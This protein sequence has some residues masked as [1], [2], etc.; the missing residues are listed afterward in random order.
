[1]HMR[2]VLLFFR[3]KTGFA[4]QSG[5]NTSMMKPGDLLTNGLSFLFCKAPQWLLDWLGI[6]PD[7]E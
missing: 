5:Y 2:Q 6:R 4:T 3:T 7:V 1:M